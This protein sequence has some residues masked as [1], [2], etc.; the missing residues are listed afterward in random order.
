MIR[1]DWLLGPGTVA[2]I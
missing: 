1:W 2:G